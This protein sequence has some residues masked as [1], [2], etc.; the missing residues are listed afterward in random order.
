M[1]F[2]KFMQPFFE[3]DDGVNLGGSEGA[4]DA[5]PADVQDKLDTGESDTGESGKEGAADQKPVQS[6]DEN[7]KYAAAR[8]EAETQAKALKDR[9]DNFAKQYGYNSF[10]ELEYAQKVKTMTDQ[11]IDP[12][13]AEL[14]VKQEQ[15]EQQIAFQGHQTRIQKEKSALQNQR[16][17]KD[18]ESEVDATLEKDPSLPVKMVFDY[19]KGQKID[20]LLAKETKAA[21]QRQLNNL[22]GKSHIKPD[23]SGVDIDTTTVDEDEWNFYHRL[24]PKA[25]KE[26]YAKFIKS[27]KRS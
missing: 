16:F 12:A 7:A 18:L 13:V 23:G 21:Q 25:K 14:K 26:D 6:Q 5:Q 11:G 8:R 24:N 17:F 22:N 20:E 2:Y 19:I 10:E 1:E 4:T 15:L 3:N 27:E 9:Q